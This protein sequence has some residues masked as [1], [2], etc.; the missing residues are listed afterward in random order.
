MAAPR[1]NTPGEEEYDS[2]DLA[3][4]IYPVINSTILA[5]PGFSHSLHRAG[6]FRAP[7]A[8]MFPPSPSTNLKLDTNIRFISN[9]WY[10]S[11]ETTPA[12]GQYGDQHALTPIGEDEHYAE[13]LALT[14]VRTPQRQLPRRRQKRSKAKIQRSCDY[15]EE[16]ALSPVFKKR[17]KLSYRPQKKSE[18]TERGGR[19][20]MTALVLCPTCKHP[21]Q[22]PLRSTKVPAQGERRN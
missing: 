22:P 15:A 8:Q 2:T 14:P 11:H 9:F 4:S 3:S 12:L 19:V 6:G 7:I 5:G 16:L 10:P 18:A 21:S 13:G 20:G 1:N 17:R